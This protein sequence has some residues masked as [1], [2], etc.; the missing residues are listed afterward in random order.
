MKEKAKINLTNIKSFIEGYSKYFYDKLIGLPI[1]IQEQVEYRHRLCAKDCIPQKGCIHCGCD[2]IG[3][4]FV[5]ESCNEGKRF[6]DLMGK[7][8]WKKF[9]K[10]NDVIEI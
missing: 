4:H 1:H 10:E 3:K 9:K 6:P 2:P 7:E 5:V 8:D